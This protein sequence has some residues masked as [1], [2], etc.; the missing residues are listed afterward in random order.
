M[1]SGRSRKRHATIFKYA[2]SLLIVVN[3]LAFIFS[4]VDSLYNACRGFFDGVEALSSVLFLLEYV[5][6]LYVAR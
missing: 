5:A 3:L 1:L 2:L 4:T 6:R